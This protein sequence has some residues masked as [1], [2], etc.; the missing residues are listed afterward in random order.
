MS[1]KEKN[2]DEIESEIFS[3]VN[4]IIKLNSNYISGVIEDHFFKRS[5]KNAM[6]NLI[7]IHFIL[8]ENNLKL[9]EILD[10]MKFT[11]EYYKAI[12]II[13]N[14]SSLNF[15]S[16]TFSSSVSSSILQIPGTTSEITASFITLMDGLKLVE[17][18]NYEFIFGLFKDLI[19][20]LEKFPGLELIKR[21]IS[22]IYDNFRSNKTQFF[23]NTQFR[24][25][26]IDEVYTMYND[27][28]QKLNLKI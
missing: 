12:S 3:L 21:K 13:N 19:T 28:Q 9:L 10:Q 16:N 2:L 7:N 17:F 26:L 20:N 25:S 18:E 23:S 15:N 24:N 14:A 8:N 4:T 5:I 22:S 6:N 11:E 27:F 1:E